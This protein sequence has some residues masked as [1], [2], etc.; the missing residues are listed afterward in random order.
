MKTI[1]DVLKELD[2]INRTIENLT[3]LHAHSGE[4]AGIYE[5]AI[6]LL[7]NYKRILCEIQIKR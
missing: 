7:T 5:D 2:E 1:G 3:D 6:D 4:R